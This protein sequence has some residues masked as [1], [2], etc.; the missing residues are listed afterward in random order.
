[1][2][3][4]DDGGNKSRKYH[5]VLLTMALIFGG[6]I[7]SAYWPAF[8]GSFPTLVGGLLAAAALYTGGNVAYKYIAGKSVAFGAPAQD[9]DSGQDGDHGAFRG[10][11]GA[12]EGDSGEHTGPAVGE[13][14]PP[15]R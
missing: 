6:A 15:S 12:S 14:V 10:S 4:P 9:P 5:I 13:A 7:L 11:G 3:D 8:S 1:M 2:L